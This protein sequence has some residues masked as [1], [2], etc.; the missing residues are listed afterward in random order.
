MEQ[1]SPLLADRN[2]DIG[3]EV[4]EVW[5]SGL[6]GLTEELD[7]APLAEYAKQLVQEDKHLTEMFG[8]LTTWMNGQP[9]L[10]K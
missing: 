8:E 10:P 3:P 1:I 5:E 4:V 2:F 6:P 7:D 9:Q